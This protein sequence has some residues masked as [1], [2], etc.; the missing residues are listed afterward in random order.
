MEKKK[1][2]KS[3]QRILTFDGKF[4]IT[5]LNEK[6][7]RYWKMMY[8]KSGVLFLTSEPGIAKSTSL[9]EMASKVIHVESGKCLRYIDLRL[10]M[11]DETDVGLFPDK[12]KIDIPTKDGK[13]REATFLNHIIPYWAYL[14]NQSPTIIHFEELNRAPL[15]VRNAALQILLEREI[16]YEFKFK[17]YVMMVATGNLGDDDGTDVEEFDSALN[18]R[19][20]HYKHKMNFDEWVKYYATEHIQSIIVSYLTVHT[21]QYYLAKKQRTETDVAYASPRTWTFL[22]DY[23]TSNYGFNARIST[24]FKDVEQVAHGYIGGGAVAFIRYLKDVLK[25]SIRDIMDRYPQI[26]RENQATFIRDKKSELLHDLKEINLKDLKKNQIENIMLFLLD[27]SPD[28][29]SAY[30]LWVVDEKYE[31]E[32]DDK[33]D[34]KKNEFILSFLQ[35]KR[36]AKYQRTLLNH[37]Q[38]GESKDSKKT[39]WD[40]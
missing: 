33:L 1:K 4:D 13:T 6:Q 8:P 26:K 31:Y 23:I 20:I 11:L 5:D 16:G 9:R 25:I 39:F 19:L 40:K 22:S 15:A 36:F 7:L 29:V 2:I 27:L 17:D 32:T 28:E 14:A 34:T 24:W 30:L 3:E 18:G 37:V 12:F 21:D 35:D 10:A 38:G